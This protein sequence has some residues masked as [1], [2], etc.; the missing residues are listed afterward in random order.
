ARE[1]W[2]RTALAAAAALSAMGLVYLLS[3]ENQANVG[4]LGEGVGRIASH[5]LG[6][7]GAEL[8]LGT[9]LLVV[10]VI[11]FEIGSSS[12]LRKL[13]GSLLAQFSPPRG[14]ANRAL[15]EEPA[16]DDPA[17]AGAVAPR[18]RRG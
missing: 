14:K 11:A 1:R 13:L 18:G 6:K 5:L 12:P 2:L 17:A 9:A 10:G 4:R 16:G 3:G 15:A 8:L 7:V